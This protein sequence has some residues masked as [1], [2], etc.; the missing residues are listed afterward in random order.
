MRRDHVADVPGLLVE[1][2]TALDAD[3]LGHR[4]L[5]VVDV[6]AVPDRLEHPVREAER[7]DVLD[8]L[9]AEVV[10]DAEDLRLVE[11]L[12]DRRVQLHR[13]R[14]VAT[15]RLLEHDLRVP[16]EVLL[17]EAG[18]DVRI[19]SRRRRGVEEA[20]AAGPVVAVGLLEMGDDVVHRAVVGELA[21]DVARGAC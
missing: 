14:E 18:N 10:I 12:V 9:L 11:D 17:G 13:A 15:E 5:H 6:A 16:V 3:V 21:R 7:E 4:E 8:G 20:P 1:D 2:A 19:G